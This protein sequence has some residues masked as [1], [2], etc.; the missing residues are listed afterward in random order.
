DVLNRMGQ[1]IAATVET[2]EGSIDTIAALTE[3]AQYLQVSVDRRRA[4]RFGIDADEL[5]DRLRAEVEGLRVGT[6]IEG[7]AR[8]P[9]MLRY[10]S[11]GGD[12]VESMRNDFI[13]LPGGGLVP[14]GELATIERVEG[15]VVINREAGQRFAVV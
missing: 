13:N 1:E 8:V 3:G 5:Q 6:V 15:P 7:G 14:L 12:G 4:G 10:A 2:V 9:L 11:H